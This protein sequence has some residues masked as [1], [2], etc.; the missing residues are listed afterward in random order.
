MPT[1]PPKPSQALTATAGSQTSEDYQ[2]GQ[3]PG[4]KSKYSGNQLSKGQ[5]KVVSLMTATAQN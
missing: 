5:K 3:Q 4:V 2:E 1:L